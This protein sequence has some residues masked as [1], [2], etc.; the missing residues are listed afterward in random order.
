MQKEY[1]TKSQNKFVKF[2][3]I[4]LIS[5]IALVFPIC[6]GIYTLLGGRAVSYTHLDVYKRQQLSGVAVILNQK[7]I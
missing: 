3:K 6:L 2:R 5:T 7:T 4:V 1:R